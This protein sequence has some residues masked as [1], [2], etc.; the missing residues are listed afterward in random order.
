MLEAKAYPFLGLEL[1]TN[2][3]RND[4][5]NTLNINRLIHYF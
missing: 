3:N 4:N 5:V 2:I 1:R